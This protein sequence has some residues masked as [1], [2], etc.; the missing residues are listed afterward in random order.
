MFGRLQWHDV[1]ARHLDRTRLPNQLM[2]ERNLT[3]ASTSGWG[4]PWR[5]AQGSRNR[6]RRGPRRRDESNGV[7]RCRYLVDAAGRGSPLAASIDLVPKEPV[8]SVSGQYWGRFRNTRNID[9]L[10]GEPSRRG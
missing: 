9:E 6:S 10:G 5:P 2:C 4:A 7:I 3:M 1:H 8:P